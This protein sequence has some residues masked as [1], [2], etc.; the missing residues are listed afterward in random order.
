MFSSRRWYAAALLAALCACSRSTAPASFERV[1]VLA[2]ENLSTRPDLDWAG[3]L[4]PGVIAAQTMGAAKFFVAAAGKHDLGALRAVKVLRGYYQVEGSTLRLRATLHDLE[5]NRAA[6]DFNEAGSLEQGP[7]PLLD[8]LSRQLAGQPRPYPH[9]NS[10]AVAALGAALLEPDAARRAEKAEAAWK[11]DPKLVPAAM[12]AAQARL[13][14]GDAAGAVRVLEAAIPAAQD[15]STTSQARLLLA[16]LKRDPGQMKVALEQAV[17]Q[18]PRN[19]DLLR[20]LGELEGRLGHHADS[21]KW[22]RAALAL[23]PRFTG[24]WNLLAYSQAYAGDFDAALASTAEYRKLGAADP[25]SFDSTGEIGWMA[26]RFTESAQAFLTAQEKDPLF[27]GGQEFAKAAFARLLA[28]DAAGADQVFS[29]YIESRRAAAD[30]IVDLRQAHWLYLSG[31]P[32][33]AIELASKIAASGGEPGARAAAFLAVWLAQ[34]DRKDDAQ[35]AAQ[36]ARSIARSPG[37]VNMAGIAALLASP[38]AS[39]AEWQKRTAAA[40]SPQAPASVTAGAM[41]YSLFLDR[42]YREAASVFERLLETVNPATADEVRALLAGSAV[43]GGDASRAAALLA[44]WPLPPTPGESLFATLWFPHV[45]DWR[46]RTLEKTNPQAAASLQS[47]Y[48]SITRRS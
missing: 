11:M 17:A 46:A 5:T 36:Q 32:R 15:A 6:R 27:L 25:N 43:L 16:F 20:E 47:L 31:R 7:L 18:S 19:T 30:P 4:A 38:A 9:S 14:I 33:E 23:E 8:R 26:G 42:H 24:L 12:E 40:F 28:G 13:G 1:A 35:K 39:P 3:A 34:Q 10:A 29:R 2:F 21:Q 44:R 45:I 48:R 41:A 37:S 22:F